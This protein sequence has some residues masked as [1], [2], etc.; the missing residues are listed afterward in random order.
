MTRRARAPRAPARLALAAG[1]LLL[2]GA[3]SAAPTPAR[4]ERY[5]TVRSG[6]T[7]ARIARR[8]RVEV[9]ELL[10]ANRMRRRSANLRV[11]QRLRVPERGEI[12]VRPGDTLAR[13]A[14]RHDVS[15]EDL[16]RMNRLRRSSRL[17]AYQRLVL[18]SYLP[19]EEERRDWGEPDAPGTVT[20]IRRRGHDEPVTLRLV[21]TERRPL[22]EALDPLGAVMRRQDDDPARAPNPRLAILLAQLSDS[23]GGRPI[24]IVSGWRSAGGY[25]RASSR[26]TQGRAA[27]IRIQGVGNRTLWE[28]C[29][30]IDHAGCGFYPRSSFVHV[31]ARMT[32][33]Q[34]VDWSR[35]GRRPRY[36]T[37]RGPANRRRRLRMSRPR[38]T[39]DLALAYEVAEPDGSFTSVVD[40]PGA[41]EDE[42]E[43]AEGE[44]EGEGEAESLTDDE[45]TDDADP[46]SEFIRAARTSARAW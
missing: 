39:S 15:V 11:G 30:R 31:D 29:R 9:E 4:A 21:D 23:F 8:Y 27:D 42:E 33:T 5:H 25:T 17:R 37:L 12:F 36:G 13:L 3:L 35:P 34:W 43:E 2:V 28:A 26:H 46:W 7:I 18:P 45:A 40:E 44:G 1:A 10:A 20:L 16:Q 24:T 38:V 14:R 19:P 41:D 22:R 32:R 6:Q